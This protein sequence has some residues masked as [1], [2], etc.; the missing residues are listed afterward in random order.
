MGSFTK[1]ISGFLLLQA[2]S[3]SPSATSGTSPGRPVYRADQ[4]GDAY[5][6]IA[7][8]LDGQYLLTYESSQPGDQSGWREIALE[9][10]R[11][12]LE[13]RTIAGYFVR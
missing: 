4:L 6:A 5:G 9:V 2:A 11:P 13:G 7:E 10:A 3:T 12:H 8:E 1:S